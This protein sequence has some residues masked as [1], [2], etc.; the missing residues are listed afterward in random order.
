MVEKII[1]NLK[2]NDCNA[3]VSELIHNDFYCNNV[4]DFYNYFGI[5][6]GTV[7]ILASYILFFKN[8]QVPRFSY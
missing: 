2:G 1:N 6:G 3:I 8:S 7:W 5:Q 4:K